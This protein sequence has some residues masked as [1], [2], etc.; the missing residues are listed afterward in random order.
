LSVL[1]VDR[2]S[3][4]VGE[5]L[6]VKNATLSINRGEVLFLLGPQRCGKVIA[7]ESF[8]RLSRLLYSLW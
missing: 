2:V 8:D 3:V 7:A 6:V 1:L 5:K 4:A